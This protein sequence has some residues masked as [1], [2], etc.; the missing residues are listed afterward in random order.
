[1]GKDEVV[2]LVDEGDRVIGSATL[3][4]CLSEGLLHR[5]VAVLVIRSRG[6]VLIQVRSKTDHWQPGRWT[7]SCTGHV[8]AGEGYEH[9]ARREL[10]EELGIRSPVAR[11]AKMLLPKVRG[12]A[13][14]E[15]E[16]VS[17]F[18]A[19]SDALPRIDPVELD[20]VR[21]LEPRELGPLMGGRRLTPDAKLMLQEYAGSIQGL[22]VSRPSRPGPRP[23]AGE[24]R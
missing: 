8:K 23:R 12:A 21:E 1:L 4:K 6:T 13:G 14:V 10:A 7:I 15:W 11:L 9:A 22:S 20:G 16:F 18:T 3:E 2:D 17:L 24:T 5:A 19:R